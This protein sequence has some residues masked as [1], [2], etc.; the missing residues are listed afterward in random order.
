MYKTRIRF[1][2]AASAAAIALCSAQAMAQQAEIVFVV[3]ESG[4][5]GSLQNFLTTFAPTLSTQLGN[6]GTTTRFGLVGFGAA[7]P[8]ARQVN[9]N[10]QQF[11]NATEFAT[12]V[13][14]LA[15]DGGFE[16]GYD[17]IN[18]VLQ[19]YQFST[20]PNTTKLIVLVTDEDRDVHNPAVTSQT[21]M[22]ALT[23]Q[24]VFL[25]GIIDQR[26]T[27][28]NGVEAVGA[29]NT[30]TYLDQ[31]GD[32]VPEIGGQPVFVP[33]FDTTTQDYTN[34]IT[35]LPRGCVADLNLQAQ[36]GTNGQAFAAAL[37]DC[38]EQIIVG[39]VPGT[40]SPF[41]AFATRDAA[42][43]AI[44]SFNTQ[45]SYRLT[46]RLGGVDTDTSSDTTASVVAAYGPT[47]EDV[48]VFNRTFGAD[49]VEPVETGTRE[50][51]VGLMKGFVSLSGEWASADYDGGFDD[52]DRRA[53][54]GSVGLDYEIAPNTIVGI[55]LGGHKATTEAGRDEVDFS[56]FT[57]GAYGGLKFGTAGYVDGA[58]S[59]SWGDADTVRFAGGG[60]NTGSTD[61]DTFAAT[62]TPGWVFD[63][64]GFKVNPSVQLGYANI[65]VD[66]Y[67]EVGPA[68][69][70]WQ[71]KDYDIFWATP[72]VDVSM[73]IMQDWGVITPSVGI[74]G[75]FQGGD[76]NDSI[77]A[78]T[79]GGA[80]TA[81]ALPDV[82]E[83][84]F[85]AAAGLSFNNDAGN[86]SARVDYTGTF[87]G[88]VQSHQ[89]TVRFRVAF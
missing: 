58:I 31:N 69:R 71:E 8:D 75:R 41:V 1:L 65:N 37:A 21:L 77:V 49:M 34:L 17:G 19:N 66:G 64:N 48:Q 33:T 10:G 67:T 26:I 25:G 61:V 27:D 56:A 72:R 13:G 3:D 55:A 86:M 30:V 24:N 39:P 42:L 35:G 6:S 44:Q 70:T 76:T 63:M 57:L 14:T 50:F 60:A 7:N 62:V 51:A 52:Y 11:G 23:L 78:T 15:I 18:Y 68:A 79:G 43:T 74:G 5:M 84:A 87:G 82:D 89:A 59:Y 73:P 47:V 40:I 80:A 2:S 38:I 9:V 12:A 54:N 22:D 36:G 28:P 32:G 81:L 83:A 20:D 16:D 45:L 53:F 29:S 46:G 85:V 4:S 88:D